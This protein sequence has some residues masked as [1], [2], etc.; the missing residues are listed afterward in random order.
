MIQ[1]PTRIKLSSLGN[2]WFVIIVTSTF[3]KLQ[4]VIWKAYSCSIY[5]GQCSFITKP[6]V[7]TLGLDVVRN[8]MKG[9]QKL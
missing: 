9:V 6:V 8:F 3:N 7:S 1:I 5:Y 4:F 2:N